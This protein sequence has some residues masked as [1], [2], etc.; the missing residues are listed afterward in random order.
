[1]RMSASAAEEGEVQ[2][3]KKARES[4]NLHPQEQMEGSGLQKCRNVLK[5]DAASVPLWGFLYPK[6]AFRV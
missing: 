3:P 5:Q 4:Q 1:M 2:I 6:E